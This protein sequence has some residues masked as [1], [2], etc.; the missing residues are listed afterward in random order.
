MKIYQILLIGIA[1][2]VCIVAKAQSKLLQPI[3]IIFQSETKGSLYPPIY[4]DD[5]KT[6]VD[7]ISLQVD[8]RLGEVVVLRTPDV[9]N[10]SIKDHSY[11]KYAPEKIWRVEVT[12]IEIRDYEIKLWG[13]S[14]GLAKGIVSLG[15]NGLLS[16]IV[17]TASRSHKIE[18]PAD[19]GD[20]F[21]LNTSIVLVSGKT[22][23]SAKLEDAITDDSVSP[24]LASK[25]LSTQEIDN[26]TRSRPDGVSLAQGIVDFEKN[27]SECRQFL[28]ERKTQG[29]DDGDHSKFAPECPPCETASCVWM[30]DRNIVSMKELAEVIKRDKQK[31]STGVNAADSK[32]AGH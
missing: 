20:G 24:E 30:R 31:A 5:F 17:H 2:S 13:L 4:Q 16:K 25:I 32:P 12:P 15:N 29:I 8:S 6:A 23:T 10:K 3:E 7:E 1:T 14:P 9:K 19:L 22:V 21:N 26:I 18:N 11:A 28:V 27:K